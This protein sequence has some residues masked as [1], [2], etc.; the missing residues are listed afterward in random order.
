MP[1]YELMYIIAGEIT[2]EQEEA[3][4]REITDFLVSLDAKIINNENI[5]KRKLAYPIQKSMRGTYML[6][7]FEALPEKLAEVDHKLRVTSG[8]IRHLVVKVDEFLP[9]PKETEGTAPLRK[10]YEK[11]GRGEKPKIHKPEV[12]I[13]LDKQIEHALEEDLS[14]QA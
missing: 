2:G 7:H 4:A 10:P 8:I 9:M 5:G 11:R 6:L 13:D 12:K 1:K 14:K 3:V